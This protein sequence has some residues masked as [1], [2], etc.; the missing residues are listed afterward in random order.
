MT[1][2]YDVAAYMRAIGVRFTG[3]RFTGETQMMKLLYYA[4]AWSLAW[5]GEPLFDER[6]EAWRKGP[7]V[8]SMRFTDPQPDPT[9]ELT[10]E[11]RATIAA[12]VE[13]YG[14]LNGGELSKLTHDE[15]PWKETRGDRPSDERCSDEITHDS[16]RREYTRQSARGAGPLRRVP[17]SHRVANRRDVLAR[18]GRARQEWGRTLEL[19]GK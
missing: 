3:V 1:T 13:H 4:Q 9:V 19:L 14:K 17:S 15:A 12:V 8:P 11:Q 5:D 10:E 7:V 18:A 16:M 2:A 6:I